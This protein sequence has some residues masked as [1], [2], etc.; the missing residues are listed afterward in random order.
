[1]DS[2]LIDGCIFF[3]GLITVEIKFS[4]SKGKMLWP[5]E[6]IE[7]GGDAR[8]WS[9]SLVGRGRN[10]KKSIRKVFEGGHHNVGTDEP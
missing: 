10:Y 7:L 4:R 9:Q 3:P 5:P 8:D 2:D 1:M 6:K